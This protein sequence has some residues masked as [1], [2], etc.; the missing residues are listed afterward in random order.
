MT[1]PDLCACLRAATDARA[2]L[3][4]LE[5]YTVCAGA[6]CYEGVQELT[7]MPV[8]IASDDGLSSL[9][10]VGALVVA[11]AALLWTAPAPALEAVTASASSSSLT[12]SGS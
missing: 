12:S 8:A 4:A 9:V 2:V 6:Q 10:V 5:Q 1:L 11:A 3:R 7:G